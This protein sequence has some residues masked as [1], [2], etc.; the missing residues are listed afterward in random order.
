M[1]FLLKKIIIYLNNKVHQ[2]KEELEKNAEAYNN[3]VKD[4]KTKG[5]KIIDIINEIRKLFELEPVKL[6]FDNKDIKYPFYEYAKKLNKGFE[7]IQEI[8]KEVQKPMKEV[9][10]VF[11]EQINL[12]TLD[13]L[14][15]M[16]ITESMQ[17][18]LE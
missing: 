11:G 15:I 13:L 5:Q 1:I 2:G 7:E 3:Y 9:M 12:V 17:D 10:K 16:D 18:L 8:K 14:F 6:K 4:L